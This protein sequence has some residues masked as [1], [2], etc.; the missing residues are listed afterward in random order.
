MNALAPIRIPGRN[1][2][3]TLDE[4][5][6]E[7]R[8]TAESYAEKSKGLKVYPEILASTIGLPTPVPVI[9]FKRTPKI[10]Q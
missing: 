8:R 4:R 5:L 10:H 3:E 1:V 6:E 2:D 9:R 7:A